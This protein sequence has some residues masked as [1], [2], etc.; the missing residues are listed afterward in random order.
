MSY[1]LGVSNIYELL[2]DEN[3]KEGSRVAAQLSKQEASKGVVKAPASSGSG[4]S[5]PKTTPQ[6]AGPRKENT[7]RQENQRSGDR[8]DRR[9]RPDNRPPRQQRASEEGGEVAKDDRR[10]NQP[11]RRREGPR[12]ERRGGFERAPGGAAPAGPTG[13]VIRERRVYERRSGTGRGREMKKGGAGRANWGNITDTGAEEPA[14]PGTEEKTEKPAE[15]APQP[16]EGTE[17]KPAEQKEESKEEEEEEDKTMTLDEYMKKKKQEKAVPFQLPPPRKVEAE[18]PEWKKFTPLQRE[19]EELKAESKPK[20]TAEE[21]KQKEQKKEKVAVDE[22][23]K[24][25]EDSPKRQQ[26]ERGPRDNKK[27][28]KKGPKTEAPKFSEANFP[29]LATTKA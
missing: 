6:G 29:A 21:K 2:D 4:Q 16:T 22:V 18:N 11:M 25:Q 23:F 7:G 5:K 19:E 9:P 27:G 26:R 12:P 1:R 28:P 10:A 13:E 17:V 15:G 14:E 3:E 20:K 8:P 24:V